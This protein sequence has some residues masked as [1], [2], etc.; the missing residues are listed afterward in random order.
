MFP[1][2]FVGNMLASQTFLVFSYVILY[3][4]FL[5]YFRYLKWLKTWNSQAIT[6]I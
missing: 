1:T 2:H 5:L 6:V 4:M 3:W